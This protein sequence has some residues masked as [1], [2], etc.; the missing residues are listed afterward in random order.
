VVKLREKDKYR[1]GNRDVLSG[2]NKGP[3]VQRWKRKSQGRIGT[4][5]GEGCEKE[6]EGIPQVHLLEQK[7]CIPS[8]KW[9]GKTGH[10]RHQKVHN[11]FFTS[12]FTYS[13]ATHVSHGP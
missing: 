3:A 13:Q 9:K 11:K 1:Q 5:I 4:E 10:N 6:E 12:V 2:K 7:E 8:D